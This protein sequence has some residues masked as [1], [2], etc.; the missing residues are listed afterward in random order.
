M[1][2]NIYAPGRYEN[3]G[4]SMLELLIVMLGAAII[5]S[6]ALPSMGEMMNNY[7]IIFAAQEI[8]TQLHFAKLKAITGNETLR[9]NFPTANSYQV[10]LSDGTLLRGPFLLPPGI[11]P[12]TA[13]TGDAVTFPGNFVTFQPDGSVPVSGNGSIGRVKLISNNGR[14]VDILV[15]RGGFIRHT[16]PYT[17]STPPF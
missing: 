15:Q 6:I 12:N 14:R 10:E 13:D 3:A 9:V 5:A 8:G 11:H 16:T 17:G 4:F 7:G 2:M 1:Q